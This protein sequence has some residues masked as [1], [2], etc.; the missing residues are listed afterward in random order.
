VLSFT[1]SHI[2][3]ENDSVKAA[4][5]TCS[6]KP[7]VNSIS[8]LVSGPYYETAATMAHP[9]SSKLS[10]GILQ[11]LS[12]TQ[13]A[14]SSLEPLSGGTANFIFKGTL[15]SPLPDGTS[16]VAV[17]H[18]E[19]FIASMPDFQLPPSRCVGFVVGYSPVKPYISSLTLEY[20]KPKKRA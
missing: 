12:S 13:Y 19:S 4:F 11:E 16:V 15:T 8:F 1:C 20:S 9:Q 6:S 7:P 2:V 3:A 17:K 18:G 5:T 14:C 10:E